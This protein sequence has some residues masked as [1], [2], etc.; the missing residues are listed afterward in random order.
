MGDAV[1]GK[2]ICICKSPEGRGSMLYSRSGKGILSHGISKTKVAV[3]LTELERKAGP[4]NAASYKNFELYS[5]N[6][7]K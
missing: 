6:N 7:A 2:T 3:I 4:D 5:E 1:Q